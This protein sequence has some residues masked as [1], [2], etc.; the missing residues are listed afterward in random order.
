MAIVLYAALTGLESTS[1][2]ASWP[3]PA[4]GV[5]PVETDSLFAS[6]AIAALVAAGKA[7]PAP[8]GSVDTTTPA[9]ML[10]GTP[11]L[12]VGVSN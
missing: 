3:I 12:R 10:R 4:G 8:P 7:T 2:V 1:C 6:A 9:E 11:G 5:F